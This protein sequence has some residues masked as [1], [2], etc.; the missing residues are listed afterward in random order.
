M[1]SKVRQNAIEICA[2]RASNTSRFSSITPP[3]SDEIGRAKGYGLARHAF[4]AVYRTSPEPREEFEIWAE[5]SLILD[6][7]W[8]IGEPL[9]YIGEKWKKT[10]TALLN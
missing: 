1:R 10:P 4:F 5:A 9:Y 3:L 2:I 8:D 6:E 7:G